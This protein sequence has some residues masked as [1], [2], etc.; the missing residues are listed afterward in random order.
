M[1][2]GFPVVKSVNR[3]IS[4]LKPNAPGKIISSTHN[5]IPLADGDDDIDAH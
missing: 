2:T 4:G 1:M 3:F 5:A